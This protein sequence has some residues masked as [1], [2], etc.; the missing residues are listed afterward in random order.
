MKDVEVNIKH[1]YLWSDDPAEALI[2]AVIFQAVF[3][4]RRAAHKGAEYYFRHGEKSDRYEWE[5]L[6]IKRFLREWGKHEILKRLEAE[7]S[8]IYD[9]I[10]KQKNRP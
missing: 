7:R 2:C 4:Y 5:M 1:S 6:D 8:I 3:D 9:E 10:R